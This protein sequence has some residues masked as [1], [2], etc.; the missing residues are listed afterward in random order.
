M[1]EFEERIN[2][3]LSDPEQMERI[4]GMAK[5]LMGGSDEKQ[6]Q[7][8]NLFGDLGID[9]AAIG[10]ISRL[11]G[12]GAQGSEKQALLEAMKPYLSEK[13]RAKMDRAMKLARL[14]SLARFAMGEMGGGDV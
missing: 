6:P 10:R 7:S 4:M 12:S 14:A 8:E 13:R 5:S 11:M 9:P 2:S 1:S 3:V